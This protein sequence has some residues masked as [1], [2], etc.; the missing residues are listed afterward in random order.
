ML[1]QKVCSD[2]LPHFGVTSCLARRD[3]LPWRGA[4]PH[5]N[6]PFS[7][8]SI[9]FPTTLLLSFLQDLDFARL[10]WSRRTRGRVISTTVRPGMDTSETIFDEEQSLPS[11]QHFCNP[12]L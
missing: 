11:H 5:K 6:L 4:L 9:H 10:L 3:I 12:A 1:C 8:S 2:I 7:S